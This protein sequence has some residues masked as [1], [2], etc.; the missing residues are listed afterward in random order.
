MVSNKN[1]VRWA[2]RAWS[3]ASLLF[4]SAFILGT[5]EPAKWPT[6]V[7]WIGL[8]CFPVGVIVG[9]LVAWRKELLGGGIAVLSLAGF[10]AWHFVVSGKLPGGPWFAL[11]AAPGLLFL[12]AGLLSR[13]TVQSRLQPVGQSL[14]S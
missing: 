8:A 13:S 4:L 9:L 3:V 7:E 5:A 1:A 11:I 12:L 14:R 2:A 6:A 10:Y